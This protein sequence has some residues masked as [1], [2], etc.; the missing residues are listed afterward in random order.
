MA[1]AE[2]DLDVQLAQTRFR[3]GLVTGWDL[4]EGA[5]VLEVGCGQGDMTAVLAEA[6]G[7][8][9]RVL[10][11]DVAQPSFGAPVTLG[12]SARRLRDGPL[13]GRLEFR[14]GC[15]VLDP[16]VSFPDSAFDAVV[17]SQCSWYFASRE[18]LAATLARVRPWAGRLCF[19]EWDLTATAPAQL[20]HLLAV[21]IQGQVEAA[22]VRGTGNVRSPFSRE[23]L[24]RLLP[25]TGWT[26]DGVR[27]ADTAGLQDAD[28]EV[29][30]CL[31]LLDAPHWRPRVPPAVV[32]LVESQADVLRA[33]ARS[34]GNAA[35]PAYALTAR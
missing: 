24:L 30:A 6:T 11:V 21:L 27:G 28:W 5:R 4:R 1:A 18:V 7:P 8:A 16:A 25:A 35:L 19:A 31:A 15:D 10:G 29:G 20:P 32:D 13:G 12:A 14:F 23:A 2:E 22:G 9:G 17:L 33:L 34:R 26:P 3:M